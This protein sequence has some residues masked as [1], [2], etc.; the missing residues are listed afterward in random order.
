MS[1]HIPGSIA[2]HL[3]EEDDKVVRRRARQRKR[4]QKDTNHKH[5]PHKFPV[6]KTEDQAQ[7]EVSC[8]LSE[9]KAVATNSFRGQQILDPK[10]LAAAIRNWYEPGKPFVVAL[11]G[12]ITE[13]V[14]I[15]GGYSTQQA[16]AFILPNGEYADLDVRIFGVDA[17]SELGYGIYLGDTHRDF[18]KLARF[19]VWN[20]RIRVGLDGTRAIRNFD[21]SGPVVLDGCAWLPHEAT[22]NLRSGMELGHP[23]EFVMIRNHKR[24]TEHGVLVQCDEHSLAYLKGM[25]A[26]YVLNND[27]SG[28]GRSA[29]QVRPHLFPW[30]TSA[31]RG[32]ILI[33]GNT[34]VDPDL[35]H[36]DGGSMFTVWNSM[37]APV[38]I[39]GN[40]LDCTYGGIAIAWQ[41]AEA[42]NYVDKDGLA[43]Q[44]VSFEDNVILARTRS[45]V[46]VNAA[47][48]VHFLGGNDLEGKD[49]HDLLI[50]SRTSTK[51]GSP[52]CKEVWFHDHGEATAMNPQTWVD[53]RDEYVALGEGRIEQ[54]LWEGP[55]KA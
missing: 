5:V 33:E 29:M 25:G 10:P 7:L 41:P 15:A 20:S 17:D 37:N 3:L 47:Q 19:E 21:V 49:G 54:M 36:G 32:P 48:E 52:P 14:F 31:Q 23:C 43:H 38:M 39:R 51:W 50:G 35:E 22:G 27:A 12:K 6:P 53:A 9:G 26:I 44:H 34:A 40:R 2:R 1:R 28:G 16:G 8:V 42:G 4:R 45:A 55:I 11:K 24:V 13:P 30:Q 18:G 46:K